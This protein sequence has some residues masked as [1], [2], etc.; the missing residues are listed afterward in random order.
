[1]ALDAATEAAIKLEYEESDLTLEAI[2]EKHGR[3]GAWVCKLAK[4]RGWKRRRP[5]VVSALPPRPRRPRNHR[6]LM[7]RRMCNV[8][9]RK[10]KQM[11]TGMKD[12]TL[13]PADLER[14]AKVVGSI[15]GGFGRMKAPTEGDKV[16]N[17]KADKAGVADDVERLQREITE[18]FERIQRRREAERGSA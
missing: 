9:N 10:L 6:A 15:L 16:L 7:D 2:G 11:E 8:I 17:P 3:S 18:R 1:M 13:S 4:L 14:D 5:P 12:G